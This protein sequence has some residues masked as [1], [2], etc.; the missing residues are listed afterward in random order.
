MA[1]NRLVWERLISCIR[2]M[3][4]KFGGHLTNYRRKHFGRHGVFTP[5]GIGLEHFPLDSG[6][7]ISCLKPRVKRLEHFE[8]KADHATFCPVGQA[9]LAEGIELI[10][11]AVLRCRKQKIEKLLLDSTG[12][13]GF[14]P[15]G[16]P[17][18]YRI[19]ERIAAIAKS[20]VK[21]AHVASPEWMHYAKFSLMV[22][23][24]RGLDAKHFRSKTRALNW[25]LVP[26]K[27]RTKRKASELFDLGE[28]KNRTGK[29]YRSE[30]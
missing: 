22:A 30:A 14:H 9:S 7:Q 19:A 11:R 3:G 28:E 5:S 4:E 16:M 26:S 20:S 2:K 13:P 24:N 6:A 18:Q 1:R 21:I 29:L 8:E 17:E 23:K 12:L 15:P 25:L 10:S 27:N